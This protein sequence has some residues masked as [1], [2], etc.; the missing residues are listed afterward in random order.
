MIFKSCLATLAAVSLVVSTSDAQK[1][2]KAPPPAP[3]PRV[4]RTVP[5]RPGETLGYDISWAAFMTAATATIS[6]KEKRPSYDSIA[7]YIV[8]EGQPTALVAAL[9]KLYYKADTLLDAYTLLPQ[10]GSLYSRE[11]GR[12]HLRAT[13]FLQ[14]AHKAQY[15]VQSGATLANVD[16]RI[17]VPIP[18]STQDAVSAIYALRAMELKPGASMVMP[19]SI[20][21]ETYR[22]RITASHKETVTCGLGTFTAWKL[23]PSLLDTQG[24]PD[25]QNMALWITD[26]HR[27]LPVLLQAD[28]SVGTFRLTLRTASGV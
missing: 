12:Q 19:V 7:Y 8:A 1:P 3:K 15:E 24:E 23:V 13:R 27:R 28:F 9:Y 18:A 6:V 20:N 22:V 25:A 2:P 26:D 16:T 5:F 21:G 11:A 17:E 14:E 10:R 4:E